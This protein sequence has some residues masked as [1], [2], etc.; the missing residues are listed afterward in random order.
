MYNLFWKGGTGMS[1][2]DFLSGMLT[3]AGIA[4]LGIAAYFGT[5]KAI[6]VVRERKYCMCDDDEYNWY[7]DE[8]D[9]EMMT[10]EE[11]KAA[12]EE[13]VKEASQNFENSDKSET[14]S[15][16]DTEND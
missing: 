14:D 1:K 3:M 5:K 15:D 11:I 13:Y 6:E 10:D 9:K 8:D 2:R 4:G 12:A 7:D 16:E